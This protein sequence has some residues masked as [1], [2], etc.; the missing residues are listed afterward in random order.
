[1]QQRLKLAQALV[2]DPRILLL[3]EPTNGLDPNG[4]ASM[5]ETVRRLAYERG[6]TVVVCSHL[7]PDI[8]RTC[9]QVVVLHRGRVRANGSIAELT[10]GD[11]H[12]LRVELLERSGAERFRSALD[13]A[14]L[15]W[16]EA[17]K[18]GLRVRAQEGATDAD[19]IL[20]LAVDSDVVISGLEPV[21]RSLED[22]FLA[23]L[24]EHDA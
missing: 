7:L 21:S 19:A 13:G 22:A 2:H 3:D 23:L 6:K 1:M 9:E 14:T 20:A 5:L 12:W 24:S 4:R 11:G 17:D 8:E 10:R 16:H 15:E 18:G